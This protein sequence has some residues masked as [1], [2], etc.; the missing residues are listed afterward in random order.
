MEIHLLS[1]QDISNLGP[2]PKKR[3]KMF[4]ETKTEI[5]DTKDGETHPRNIDWVRE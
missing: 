5:L 3:E 4:P 1:L 2:L